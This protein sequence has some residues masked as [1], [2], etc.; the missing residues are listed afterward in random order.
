MSITYA[1]ETAVTIKRDDQR[2]AEIDAQI[3]NCLTLMTSITT[4][5]AQEYTIFGS[6]MVKNA[7]IAELTNTIDA[8]EKLKGK[9]ERRVLMARG[10]TGRNH[11][12][13]RGHSSD[14]IDE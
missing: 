3:S 10:F 9:Y 2:L 13:M 7:A 6:R 8:L 12:D 4:G 5:T 11:A 14:G 1:T